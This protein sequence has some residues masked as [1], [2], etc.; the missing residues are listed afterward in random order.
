MFIPT[1]MRYTAKQTAAT[2]KLVSCSHCGKD[3]VYLMQRTASG[4]GSSPLFL[5]NDGAQHRA[6]A[7]ATRSLS[8]KL[9]HEFDVVPCVHCRKFQ[10]RM[11]SRMRFRRH[12]WLGMVGV[13][14]VVISSIV[15]L[16]M[17]SPDPRPRAAPPPP[18]AQMLIYPGIGLAMIA[19]YIALWIRFDPNEL[20]DEEKAKRCPSPAM[21]REAFEARLAENT[22]AGYVSV[23]PSALFLKRMSPQALAPMTVPPRPVRR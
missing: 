18:L 1:G 23:D 6:A 13:A 12:M 3:F 9:Q 10:P 19:L 4:S 11:A 5:D 2:V 7:S 21:D 17:Q 15:I 20:S 22:Q 14:V 16:I 8:A